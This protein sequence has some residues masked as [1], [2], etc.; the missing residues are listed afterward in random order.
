MKC[1]MCS[2]DVKFAWMEIGD[3]CICTRCWRNEEQKEI[4]DDESVRNI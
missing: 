2:R 3:N 1:S 4:S